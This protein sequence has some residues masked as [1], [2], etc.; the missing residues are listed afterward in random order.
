MLFSVSFFNFRVPILDILGPFL[1][2]RCWRSRKVD[3][4]GPEVHE[5]QIETVNLNI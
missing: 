2:A 4:E 3:Q 1:T 5:N